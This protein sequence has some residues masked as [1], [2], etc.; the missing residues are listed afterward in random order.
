VLDGASERVVLGNSASAFQFEMQSGVPIFVSPAVCNFTSV[1]VF[2]N[3]GAVTVP[4][5]FGQ[6]QQRKSLSGSAKGRLV[7]LLKWG[8]VITWVAAWSP[9]RRAGTE[10]PF[11]RQRS[12]SGAL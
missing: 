8:R 10:R 9:R 2:D 4:I 11:N 12:C 7:S 5:Q 3:A 1:T 6:S